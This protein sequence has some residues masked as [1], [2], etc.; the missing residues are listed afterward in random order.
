MGCCSLSLIVEFH[1]GFLGR[2]LTRNFLLVGFLSLFG[3]LFCISDH[4]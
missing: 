4:G 3:L 2:V 1:A